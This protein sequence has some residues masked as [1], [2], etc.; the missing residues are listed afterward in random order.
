MPIK[1]LLLHNILLNDFLH[2]RDTIGGNLAGVEL[3]LPDYFVLCYQDIARGTYL[4]VD[5][6]EELVAWERALRD[7]DADVQQEVA[8]KVAD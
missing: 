6:S 8:V 3:C 5:M 2:V 7:Q 4:G 1:T